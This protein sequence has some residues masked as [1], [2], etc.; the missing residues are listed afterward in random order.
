MLTRMAPGPAY[1]RRF[2]ADISGR[3]FYRETL[4]ECLRATRAGGFALVLTLGLA[5]PGAAKTEKPTFAAEE[6]FR[7]LNQR[8]Y[9]EAADLLSAS[10]HAAVEQLG[11]RAGSKSSRAVTLP[12]VLAQTFALMHGQANAAQSGKGREGETLMPQRIGFFVPGQYYVIGKYAAVFT[13]E[14]YDIAH[15][16]T[17]PV[18]DDPRKLWI[19]PTNVLSKVRDEAYFKQW[20]VWEDDHLTMPGLVW[21]VREA[22]GWK[23]DLFGGGVP[24]KAFADILRWHFGRDVFE[25]EKSKTPAASAAPAN[26]PAP[27]NQTP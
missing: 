10:D 26:P 23:I 22:D 20:W 13:R 17:G 16:D 18:R 4:C 6:F 21:L 7:A 3:P 9:E 2:Q 8:Q 5:L 24:R 19:D 27:K 11:A 1:E 14:T 12:A 25:E 15:A